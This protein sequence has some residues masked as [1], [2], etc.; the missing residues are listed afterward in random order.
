MSDKCLESFLMMPGQPIN[1]KTSITCPDCSET[2]FI[3]KWF[4]LYSID[5][6]E[7]VFHILT[8]VITA[9]LFQ[10]FLTEPV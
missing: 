10:P 3:D 9:Y 7:I 2:I 8:A 6:R 4:C 1:R 5:S